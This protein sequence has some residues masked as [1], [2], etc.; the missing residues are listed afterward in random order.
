MSYFVTVLGLYLITCPSLTLLRCILNKRSAVALYWYSSLQDQLICVAYLCSLSPRNQSEL[1]GCIVWN[2]HNTVFGLQWSAISNR[3]FPGPTRVLDANSISIASAVFAGLTRW[4]TDRQT[5]KP[6]Y[7]VI[8]TSWRRGIG[9][10]CSNN[11]C[12]FN[13]SN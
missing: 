8:L 9:I 6:R 12:E 11:L 3:W 7:F 13:C 10:L 4:Q 2:E 5:D 1:D